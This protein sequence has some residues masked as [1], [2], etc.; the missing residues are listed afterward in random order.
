MIKKILEAKSVRSVLIEEVNGFEMKDISSV[1]TDG[2]ARDLAI[3]W[4]KWQSEQS[5]S[6]GELVEYQDYFEQLAK[7]FGLEDE[8]KE[9]GII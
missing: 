5:L 4:Q 2:E 8:F 3:D 6:Q 9:N 7:K 1:Q